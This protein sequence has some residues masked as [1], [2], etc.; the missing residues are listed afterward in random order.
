MVMLTDPLVTTDWLAANLDG[1]RIVDGTWSLPG[2]EGALPEGFIAGASVFD[3]DKVAD[4]S[5]SMAHMLPSADVF[6]EA[7]GKM[8]ITIDDTVV[9]YDRHGVFSAPRVWWTFRMFGHKN[10]YVLDGGLPAWIKAGHKIEPNPSSFS[11]SFYKVTP[12]RAKVVSFDDIATAIASKTQIVDA[13]PPG[14]F[15]GSAPEPR[16]GLSSGHMPGAANIPFGALRTKDMHFRS[17]S[18]IAQMFQNIDL[19]APII[20]SCGS[21]ITAAG[22]AFN[23]ARLGASDVS[24]YD[25]SWTEYGARDTAQIVKD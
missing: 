12:A 2:S 1:V 14:R 20:T 3:L 19:T 23:L 24:V 8:G 16:P 4:T 10:V 21:G 13:R 6:A 25:G 22:L 7:V 11:K 9:I 15:K 5:S 17:L 18:E